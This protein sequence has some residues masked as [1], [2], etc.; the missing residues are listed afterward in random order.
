MKIQTIF[1]PQTFLNGI[2]NVLE[3]SSFPARSELMRFILTRFLKKQALIQAQIKH[4]SEACGKP[5][6]DKKS[7]ITVS[8][9][10]TQHEEIHKL[11]GTDKPY[12]S[13]CEFTRLAIYNFFEEV[14]L[15]PNHLFFAPQIEEEIRIAENNTSKVKPGI[16]KDITILWDMDPKTNEPIYKTVSLV[17]K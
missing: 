11:C 9:E 10:K 5:I 12:L 17:M 3:N 8:L 6:S 4:L 1:I 2:E 16:E 7:I 13:V 15:T 14:L